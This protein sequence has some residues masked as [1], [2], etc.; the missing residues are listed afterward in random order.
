MVRPK[1]RYSHIL[2][3][4]LLLLLLLNYPFL[5]SFKNLNN[6]SSTNKPHKLKPGA[7]K[8]YSDSEEDDEEEDED[9][10]PSLPVK[11]KG[12]PKQ[13][14]SVSAEVYGLWNK[15]GVYKPKIIPKSEDQKDRIR[16]RLN[17][18]FIFQ[19]LDDNEKNIVI[20]AMDERSFKLVHLLSFL[21]TPFP[22]LLPSLLR[23]TSVLPPPSLFTFF[24]F[25]FPLFPPST[26]L[27][28]LN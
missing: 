19:S 4:L 12:L 2:L 26:V 20:D 21:L 1:R 15:K 6:T 10:A 16:K 27:I 23:P 3:L 28:I 18:S 24:L 17:Q 7:T 13:R 11:L 22:S 9:H 14:S 25:S 8:A 5:D